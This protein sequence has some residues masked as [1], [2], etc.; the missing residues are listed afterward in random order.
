VALNLFFQHQN[1]IFMLKKGSLTNLD[2]ALNAE[3]PANKPM[4]AAVVTTS[5]VKCM[6]LFVQSVA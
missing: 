4:A 5:S 3:L 1:K 6:K 2:V